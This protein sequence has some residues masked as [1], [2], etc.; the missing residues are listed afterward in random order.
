LRNVNVIEQLRVLDNEVKFQILALLTETG[1]KSITDISK[2]LNLNFSTAHKYL[3]QL[4]KVG[5]LRSK[6]ETENRLKRM[7][8]VQDFYINVNPRNVSQILRGEKVDMDEDAYGQFNLITDSGKL[9][10]FN[11]FKFAQAYIDLGVPKSTIEVI[12]DSIKS[13]IYEGITWRELKTFFNESLSNRLKIANLALN[14]VNDN[15]LYDNTIKSKL[16]V[17]NS[18]ALQDHVDG[19]IFI[20]NLSNVKLFNLVHDIR[21]LIIHGVSG[22]APETLK[23]LFDDLFMVMNREEFRGITHLL[24]N[25]NYFIAPLAKNM[26]DAELYNE[27]LLFFNKLK[28]KGVKVCIG[29]EHGMPK[30]L[31]GVS[32]TFFNIKSSYLDFSDTADKIFQA[33]LDI[34]NKYTFNSCLVIKLNTENIPKDIPKGSFVIDRKDADSN[35]S[36]IGSTTF[37]ST[38]RGWLKTMRTGDIESIAVNLVYLAEHSKTQQEFSEKLDNVIEDILSYHLSISEKVYAHFMRY[39]NTSYPSVQRGTWMYIQFNHFQYCIP[40]YGLELLKSMG[41]DDEFIIKQVQKIHAKIMEASKRYETR[42]CIRLVRKK[43]HNYYFSNVNRL[44]FGIDVNKIKPNTAIFEKTQNYIDGGYMFESSK[45]D[46]DLLKKHKILK[47]KK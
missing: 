41:Y 8:Y 32:H 2:Q 43:V 39:V 30:Y 11:K 45:V 12:F 19:K 24:E 31:E 4:E 37:D 6:Q 16:L 40:I 22:K 47:I 21:A 42:F 29:L 26:S 5:F 25:F 18:K 33:V 36:Y 28:A 13:K 44:K 9:E 27:L 15:E 23:E 46:K 38:W 7:F 35:T 3:E 20:S 1:A 10:R 17:S 14:K 34:Y